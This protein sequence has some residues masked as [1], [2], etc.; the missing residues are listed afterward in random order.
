MAILNDTE[1]VI[2]VKGGTSFTVEIP[3]Q[4]GTGYSWLYDTASTQCQLVEKTSKSSS[5]E[6]PGGTKYQV[7]TFRAPADFEED[8]IRF[9]LRRSFEPHATPANTKRVKV[10]RL[11]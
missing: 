4:S 1:T 11:Q 5:S 2:N 6:V 10:K 9:E 3:L 7:F 8:V